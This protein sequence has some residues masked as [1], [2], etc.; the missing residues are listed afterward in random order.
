M[1]KKLGPKTY[2]YP[3]TTTIVGANVKGN[4]NFCTIAFIGIVNYEPAMIAL[5]INSAHYTFD[6]IKE[7]K[8]FSV[9]IP[10]EDQIIITDYVGL[11]SGKKIEKKELFDVFYGDLETAPLIAEFPL[12]LE[13]KVRDILDYGG[14]DKVVIGEIIQVHANE[15]ILGDNDIP[16]MSKIKPIL[17]SMYENKY[18]NIGKQIG[19]AWSEGK[20]FKRI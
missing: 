4:A 9:N 5:G 1:K 16:N 12:S 13:C 20:K 14:I 10:N 19:N 18:Y 8:T 15:E 6:G 17:F 3:M 7:S 2:F 11:T